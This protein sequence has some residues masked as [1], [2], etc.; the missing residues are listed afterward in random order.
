MV[1]S[2]MKEFINEPR[3]ILDEDFKKAHI[4]IEEHICIACGRKWGCVIINNLVRF[5]DIR[6]LISKGIY[7]SPLCSECPGKRIN[8]FIDS[9]LE[10][11]KKKN[12]NS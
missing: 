8:E 6:S 4:K 2:R 9:K 11:S 3:I 5:G 12:I 7:I 10:E 1:D